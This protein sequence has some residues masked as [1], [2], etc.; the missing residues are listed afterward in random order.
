MH[1]KNKKWYIFN[2]S[3][4]HIEEIEFVDKKDALEYQRL[5]NINGQLFYP[6]IGHPLYQELP[7]GVLFRFM[8]GVTIYRKVD[9]E[10]YFSIG[11]NPIIMKKLG[12][13]YHSG[14]YYKLLLDPSECNYKTVEQQ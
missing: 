3:T 4:Q 2:L 11:S 10:I 14:P 9:S 12:A 13:V 6:K 1:L 7:D 5:H 8:D